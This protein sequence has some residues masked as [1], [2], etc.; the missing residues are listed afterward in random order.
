MR[1]LVS[2]GPVWAEGGSFCCAWEEGQSQDTGDR[3]ETGS[4]S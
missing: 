2:G 4:K 3:R 1:D